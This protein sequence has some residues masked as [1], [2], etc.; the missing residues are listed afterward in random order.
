[1]SLKQSKTK[2]QISYFYWMIIICTD[3][4]RLPLSGYMLSKVPFRPPFCV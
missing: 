1:L 4:K 2:K 3:I